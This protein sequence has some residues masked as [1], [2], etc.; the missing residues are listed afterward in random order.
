[1]L[2]LAVIFPI[3]AGFAMLALPLRTRRARELA[4]EGVTLAT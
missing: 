1:M 2:S 4:V 3:A